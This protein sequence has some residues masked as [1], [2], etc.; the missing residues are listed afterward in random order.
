MWMPAACPRSYESKLQARRPRCQSALP[1]ALPSAACINF[2]LEDFLAQEHNSFC[3]SFCA[4]QI[5]ILT[6][7]CALDLLFHI[8]VLS[9][10]SSTFCFSSTWPFIRALLT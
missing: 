3:F 8:A 6:Y 1:F 5:R 9:D 2:F 4:I 7:Y 10:F